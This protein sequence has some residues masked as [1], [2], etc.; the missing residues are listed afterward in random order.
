VTKGGGM[1]FRWTEGRKV[2]AW[3]LC[4][5]GLSGRSDE[6]WTGQCA[7]LDAHRPRSRLHRTYTSPENSRPHLS[8]YRFFGE[9]MPPPFWVLAIQ[10]SHVPAFLGTG[11]SKKPCPRLSSYRFFKEAMP[12]PFWVSVL[13]GNHALAFLGTG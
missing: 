3:V 5:R 1:A 7:P 6:P 8:G 10:R 2:G 11:Y 12:T 13:Q 4:G 9:A